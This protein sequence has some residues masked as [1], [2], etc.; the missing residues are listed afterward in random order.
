MRLTLSIGPHRAGGF[1]LMIVLVQIASGTGLFYTTA[2]EDTEHRAQRGGPVQRV[3]TFR[4]RGLNVVA[5][6]DTLLLTRQIS[7]IDDAGLLEDFRVRF[8]RGGSTAGPDPAIVAQNETIVTD[9]Q[10]LGES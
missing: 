5:T 1:I 10:A 4:S 3:A 8:R 2:V 7:L 9:L 6:L